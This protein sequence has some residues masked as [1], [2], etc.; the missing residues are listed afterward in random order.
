MIS[1]NQSQRNSEHSKNIPRIENEY[2]FLDVQINQDESLQRDPS[3]TE[4]SEEESERSEVQS[5]YPNDYD[6][7]AKTIIS[8]EWS[9]N[10]AGSSKKEGDHSISHLNNGI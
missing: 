5:D 6:D 8:S 1:E 7:V 9:D 3:N 2:Y 10:F 4:E